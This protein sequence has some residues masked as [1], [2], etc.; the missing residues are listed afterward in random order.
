MG[1]GI[2]PL[3]VSLHSGKPQ[4]FLI[5]GSTSLP[6]AP[7]PGSLTTSPFHT[8]FP[9][10]SPLPWPVAPFL[11]PSSQSSFSSPSFPSLLPCPSFLSLSSLNHTLPMVQK[12]RLRQGQQGLPRSHKPFCALWLYSPSYFPSFS[13]HFCLFPFQSFSL[14]KPLSLSLPSH[15]PLP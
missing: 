8:H 1:E 2:K 5:S 14:F 7:R 12:R 9:S 3:P 15:P 10:M 6:A 4:T 13:P 11:P